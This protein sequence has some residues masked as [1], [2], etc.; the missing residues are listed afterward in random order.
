MIKCVNLFFKIENLFWNVE[1]KSN[2]F[3]LLRFE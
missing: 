3:K 1:L 2:L